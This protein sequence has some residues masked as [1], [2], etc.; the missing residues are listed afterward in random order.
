MKKLILF[1]LFFSTN[2][3]SGE[4]LTLVCKGITTRFYSITKDFKDIQESK[5]YIFK[6]GEIKYLFSGVICKWTPTFISCK[7]PNDQPLIG[8]DRVSGVVNEHLNIG[9]MDDMF[10]GNCVP[11]KPKF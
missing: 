11:A 3:Y 8:I 4:D 5:T 2:A 6:N 10:K 9:G 1:F 7:G